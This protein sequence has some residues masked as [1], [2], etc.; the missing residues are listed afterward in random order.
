M[1]KYN[2][3]TELEKYLNNEPFDKYLTQEIAEKFSIFISREIELGKRKKWDFTGY[4]NFIKKL[5][6]D[7]IHITTKLSLVNKYLTSDDTVNVTDD[8]IYKIFKKE[9]NGNVKI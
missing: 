8:E 3:N 6:W 9:I 2:F 4:N 1:K 5:W 7:S